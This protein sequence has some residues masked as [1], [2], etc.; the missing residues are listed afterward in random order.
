MEP[1][2]YKGFVLLNLTEEAQEHRDKGLGLP[3]KGVMLHSV[4]G[5]TSE[6]CW[7]QYTAKFC[8][9]KEK[10]KAQGYIVVPCNITIDFDITY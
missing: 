3:N 8:T 6:E 7:E 2:K 5:Q 10:L 1:R 9:T 4:N